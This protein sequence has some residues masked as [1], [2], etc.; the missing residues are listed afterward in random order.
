[1]RRARLPSS[2]RRPPLPRRTRKRFAAPVEVGLVERQRLVDA[3]A[4][5]PQ[6]DDQPSQAASV[7]PVAGVAHDGD[8]LLD[9]GRVG[10]VAPILMPGGDQRKIRATWPANDDDRRPPAATAT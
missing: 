6:H 4:G 3:K 1:M 5:A 7:H 9:R 2:R 8:D 10:R